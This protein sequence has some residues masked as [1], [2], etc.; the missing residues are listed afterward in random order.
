MKN[1]KLTEYQHLF[2]LIGFPISHSFSKKY[3]S[4]KFLNEGINNCLY[5]LFPLRDISELPYLIEDFPNLTGLNV[6]LPYKELVIP[7]LDEIEESV[8]E[9]GAVNTIKIESGKLTG[10]NTDA[11]GF[12][13]SLFQFLNENQ[14]KSINKALVLGT[15][16]ASKAVK[17]VLKKLEI[18]YFMVSRDA[19]KGDFTYDDLTANL[20]AECQLIINTTPLGMA[21]KMD[22]F[23][24][25]K[26]DLLDSN[27]FLYDLVYNPEKTVF[28]AKG[29]KQGCSIINGLPMLYLQ[30]EKAWELWNSIVDKK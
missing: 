2:G 20:I 17:Y 10:Y 1:K 9:I 13:E 3:F 12:E 8:K 29:E 15:G 4:N 18:S 25:L 5:E 22:S 28:L 21:P 11:F 7:Y 16:G 23:P 6:T 14:I 30:A 24:K 19:E 27:H 26:Y